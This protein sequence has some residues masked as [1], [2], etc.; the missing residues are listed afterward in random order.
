MV[1]GYEELYCESG[2]E[3]DLNRN[4]DISFITEV[5]DGLCSCDRGVK[6]CD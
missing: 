3:A 1:L 4:K 2:F 6:V 5:V